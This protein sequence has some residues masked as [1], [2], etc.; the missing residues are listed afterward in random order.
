VALLEVSGLTL[1]YGGVVALDR[2]DLAVD[3]GVICGVIG[4]N[5]AGKTTLFNC[6]TRLATPDSGRIGFAGEDLLRRRPHRIAALGIARTF[7]NLAL[8]GGLT[9]RENVMVGGAHTVRTGFWSGAL[10]PP[11]ARRAEAEL[12]DRADD[13]MARLDLLPVADRPAGDVPYGTAKRVELARALCARPRLLLL[14]EPATGLTH[15]EVGELADLIAAIRADHELTIVVVEHHMGLVMGIS[16]KIVV[17][18]FG[19]KI[20]E[21]TPSE[22]RQDPAVIEAYLGTAA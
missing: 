4:P 22:V 13:L 9:V 21:G 20:A 16:E 8:V 6:V 14:D 7:Q 10:S 2:V 18:D 5:G 3:E 19:R 12:A 11:S 15:G 17:L 1:R